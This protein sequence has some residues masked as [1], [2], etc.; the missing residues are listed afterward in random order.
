[1]KFSCMDTGGSPGKGLAISWRLLILAD[2]CIHRHAR[3]RAQ[4]TNPSVLC[5]IVC[6]AILLDVPQG[7]ASP[8]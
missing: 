6:C 3:H 7:R 4:K 2:A 1:V 8:P 5:P